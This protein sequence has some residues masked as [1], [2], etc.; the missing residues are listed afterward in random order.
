MAISRVTQSMMSQH[1]LSSLQTS[2]SKLAAIQEQ[3]STGRVLNRP[4]DSPSDTMT[5]MRMRSSISD[6]KLYARNAEDGL[7]W[8]GQ[9]ETA[10]TGINSEVRRARDLALQGA[11][12][13]LGQT[14]LDALA[15]EVDKIR[16]G[17]L[18]SANTTY[19]GRPVFGGITGGTQAYNPATGAYIGT[20]G[21]VNRTV[22]DGVTVDIQIDGQTAFGPNG[23]SLFDDLTA[24]SAALRAGDT[25]AIRAG[26]SALSTD[27]DRIQGRI[28]DVGT[29]FNRLE[30]AA[31]TAGDVELDLTTKLSEVENTDL[32]KAMVELKMQEVAYQAALASTARVMQ[33]SLLDFLR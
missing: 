25:T 28:S 21:A 12:G 24:L 20:P 14:S 18:A 30:K 8:L 13:S 15:V 6:Q 16:E 4:S 11:N 5:S 1:S 2:L 22:A 26:S 19:L 32:P 23:S 17:V 7:G 31:T 27:M 9:T 10:L 29:Q 3:V 33:P